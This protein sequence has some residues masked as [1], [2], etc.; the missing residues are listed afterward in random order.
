MRV[1]TLVP[2]YPPTSMVGAWMATHRFLAHLVRRGH[3]VDVL[4]ARVHGT[5]IGQL[6]GV[7]IGPALP[8]VLETAVATA[9]VVISHV[10]DT[11]KAAALADRWSKP[12]VRMAH[13]RIANVD[14]ITGA[15]LI[16]F[17]SHNLAASV[18]CPSPWIVC[19]PPV[20]A[21]DYRTIP[22]DR[23]TLV[24]MSEAK[25]GELFWRL[26]R[27]LP[28]RQFLGVRGH[29]GAQ[30]VGNNTATN[31]DVVATTPAMRDIYGRTRILLMPSIEETFGMTAIEAAASGIPTIAHP[32]AGL[33]ESLGD[34]GVFVD[35]A[36]GQGW[37]DTIERL[38]DPHEWAH[39][40]EMARR[41]S[42]E[43]DPTIELDRFA[44]A[45]E[46]LVGATCVS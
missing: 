33:I 32:T 3:H 43:L 37:V 29:Y 35:R 9:D 7:N 42:A 18:E 39:A 5:G 28:H 21:D 15:A 31:V 38:H 45:I 36:D 22:G 11:A 2:A 23:V 44:D 40:S 34:A 30:Y 20:I 8:V 13:G 46:S 4:T 16:V 10:G 27:V 26:A 17:N 12:N 24:N 25:G 6:D 14:M 1:A 41:R 19:H